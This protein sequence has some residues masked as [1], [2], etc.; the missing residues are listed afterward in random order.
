[1]STFE[2]LTSFL[3]MLS[4][5]RDNSRIVWLT[6][7]TLIGS[8]RYFAGPDAR[9][10]CT[11]IGRFK[12]SICR[13]C[14]VRPP[15][16]PS[17]SRPC[18]DLLPPHGT[19]TCTPH[20]NQTRR[21]RHMDAATRR[22]PRVRTCE[23]R[24]RSVHQPLACCAALSFFH[25]SSVCVHR[26]L[27]VCVACDDHL[28]TTGGLSPRKTGIWMVVHPYSKTMRT[29]VVPDAT[30]TNNDDTHNTDETTHIIDAGMNAHSRCFVH[31]IS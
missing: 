9:Q 16:N 13:G 20:H 31:L 19:V 18:A 27:S 28:T 1:M 25:P 22:I 15:H 29:T 14:A 7:M 11:S 24:K 10:T 26:R 2:N 30:H 5:G 12:I 21:S 23:C 17:P 3:R 4:D 8:S 6:C